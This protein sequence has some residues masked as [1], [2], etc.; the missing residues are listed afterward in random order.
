MIY[1]QLATRLII[2]YLYN[3]LLGY[4]NVIHSLF[5]CLISCTFSISQ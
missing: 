4:I 5:A 1:D 3:K 2:V